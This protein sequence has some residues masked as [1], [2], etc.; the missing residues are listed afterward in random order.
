M[1]SGQA[2][3]SFFPQAAVRTVDTE[4]FRIT[5][6]I[7]TVGLDRYNTVVLPRGCQPEHYLK[8]P[9]VLWLH[10]QDFNVPG[11]PVGKCVE[12]N[13]GDSEITATTEFN[14]NDPLAVRV[15]NAYKDGFMRAWSIGFMPK[16]AEEITPLN[17]SEIKEKYNL[18]N[19][20]LTQED[21]DKNPWG[22]YVVTEWELLEYSC[23]PVPGNA[24]CLSDEAVD[25]FSRELV[26]RGIMVE[27]E[28][29]GINFRDLL[30]NKEE[31]EREVMEMKDA[32]E[33]PKE[34]IKPEETQ[35]A[36]TTETP[37]T[38]QTE[39][40]TVE[41]KTEE[42]ETEKPST[43]PTAEGEQ[44]TETVTEETT[45]EPPVAVIT[46]TDETTENLRSE[47]SELNQRNSELSERIT[48]LEA[49]VAEVATMRT[50]LA[51]IKKSVEVDNIEVTRQVAQ[52][53][54]SGSSN[55]GTFF[56]DLI[57]NRS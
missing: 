11:V 32:P 54:K 6:V 50:E 7:N 25:K 27:E 23:V 16:S 10:N 31:K 17:Y 19:L 38:T 40:T 55:A 41:A 46:Y 42:A 9:V 57:R 43:E 15:F 3:R 28:V 33:T 29:R 8:N 4:N 2:N 48:K 49:L 26:T 44:V 53:V 45:T 39:E 35:E 18:V 34:E 20:N 12:L 1:K 36:Q 22:F 37:E 30:K 51:V 14:R 56:S 24:E 52:K 47:I 21:F 13:I 5:H